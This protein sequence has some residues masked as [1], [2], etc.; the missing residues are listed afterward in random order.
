MSL[1]FVHLDPR[2]PSTR[3]TRPPSDPPSLPVPHRRSPR[4]PARV[5]PDSRRTSGP[6]LRRAA[7]LLSRPTRALSRQVFT[8]R[9]QPQTGDAKAGGGAAAGG[10]G[11]GGGGV[12]ATGCPVFWEVVLK[13]F[14]LNSVLLPSPPPSP[15]SAAARMD[16]H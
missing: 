2:P 9:R 3:I 6:A 15:P 10:G 14:L 1:H 7:K 16:T 12:G 13:A 5:V 8:V 11:G 4:A